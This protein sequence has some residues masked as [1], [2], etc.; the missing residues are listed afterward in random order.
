MA[1]ILFVEDDPVMLQSVSDWLKFE[2]HK[3]ETT[4]SGKEALELLNTYDYELI[5]LDWELKELS[6][7]EVC[8]NFRSRGGRTP[9]LFLTGRGS[10][11]DKEAGLDSG[12]DD[13]L[14]KPFQVRELSA[15]VRALLRRLSENKNPVLQLGPL[16]LNPATRRVEKNSRPIDL[17]R[18]EF[19]LL[20]LFMRN[21]DRVLSAELIMERVWSTENPCSP[22]TLRTCLKKLRGRIDE[23][24]EPSLIKNLHGVGYIMESNSNS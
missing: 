2:G 9:I 20:E 23:P 4:A 1:K 14:S 5:I 17:P 21:P 16:S 10:V 22:E 12:G 11:L 3:L 18:Q 8:R 13:Y 19:A 6:G 24:G 7:I 15:R